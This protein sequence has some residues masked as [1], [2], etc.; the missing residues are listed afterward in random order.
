MSFDKPTSHTEHLRM[1]TVT[2]H[3]LNRLTV[4]N[5][6]FKLMRINNIAFIDWIVRFFFLCARFGFFTRKSQLVDHMLYFFLLPFVFERGIDF[7]S[8]Y[9][10]RLSDCFDGVSGGVDVDRRYFK[11]DAILGLRIS[12]GCW[13]YVYFFAFG[14]YEIKLAWD[15]G[16]H[17]KVKT[18]EDFMEHLDREVMAFAWP[19]FWARTVK[20]Q[21]NF[22]TTIHVGTFAYT[23]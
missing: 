12:V 5:R 19:T 18:V 10:Y 6:H 21:R 2:F 1:K 14:A 3:V 20:R 8:L 23:N 13:I 15:D 4:I 22:H 17:H 7:K 16:K 9:D 11:L